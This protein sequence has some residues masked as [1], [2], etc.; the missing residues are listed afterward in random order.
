MIDAIERM[1]SQGIHPKEVSKAVVHAINNLK[2]KL[3]Y[4]VGKDAEELIEASRNLSE[5]HF[6]RIIAQN[7]L[8]KERQQPRQEKAELALQ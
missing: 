2:P 7:V 4:T 1:V 5:E 6:Y 3:R 8:K